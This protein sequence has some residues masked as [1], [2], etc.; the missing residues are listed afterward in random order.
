MRRVIAKT[1]SLCPECLARIPAERVKQGNQILL[2]K[3]CDRH[4]FFQTPI[5]TGEPSFA[6]WQAGAACSA[7]SAGKENENC[8]FSCGD[9]G[10]HLQKTCCALLE[11]TQRCDLYCPVCFASARESDCLDP[12][13]D[14]LETILRAVAEKSPDINIQLSGGEPCTRDDLPQIVSL[15]RSTGFPFVQLNTN[16]L[17][18]ARDRAFLKELKARGLA[19]VFLQFDGTDDSI[20][21]I[22]RGRDLLALKKA[23][24]EQ[25]MEQHLGVVLVPT[26]VPGVNTGTMGDII[27]FAKEHA[28]C[29]RGVHF[30]P[31][32][33]FGRYP[34]LPENEQRITLP[35]VISLLE[36]QTGGMMKPEHFRPPGGPH[37]LC[38]F[39]ATY[40]LL[41]DGRLQ[42]LAGEQSP[43]CAAS[44]ASD[45]TRA[46][47][48]HQW[49]YPEQSC[50]CEGGLS[51][52]SLGGWD[53]FIQRARTHTFCVSAMAFQDVWTV[54]LERLRQCYL[55]VI[56]ARGSL[57]PF[58]AY[59]L[60]A[61]NGK[62]LYRNK[63]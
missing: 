34:F 31:V 10:A 45:K 21:R 18:I 51:G 26:L 32:S 42:P 62:T 46:F 35:E 24:I 39:R 15:V 38:S 19:T 44:D 3:T 22:I 17:R 20:Y 29:V 55:R 61:R 52:P 8:P 40:V 5:W 11:V 63:L 1:E 43:C 53:D 48:A 9:C 59:N 16:G 27:A 23:A 50:C 60:T 54:D 28:P 57:I 4:G 58:C 6:S 56:D 13:I 33:Y 2:E 47:V 36:A 25:C 7:K 37:P 49:R 12:A 41:E 30:Q 14:R